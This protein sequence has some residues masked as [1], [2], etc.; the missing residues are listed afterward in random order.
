MWDLTT[1]VHIGQA[2]ECACTGTL[3]LF[4]PFT[5]KYFFFQKMSDKYFHIP[6]SDAGI[7]G[8]KQINK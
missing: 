5:L 6:P 3:M 8:N 2:W 7:S 1:F 4:L